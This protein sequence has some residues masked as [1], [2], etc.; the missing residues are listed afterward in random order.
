MS[1]VVINS[2]GL[3]NEIDVFKSSLSNIRNIF[4][5]EQKMLLVMNNG[6]SWVGT[7]QEAMYNKMISFQNNFEPVLEALQ[8]YIDFMQKASDDYKRFEETRNK[9]LEESSNELNVNSQ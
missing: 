2:E 6:H 8:V 4:E 3:E 7:A 9:N 5:S 1:V